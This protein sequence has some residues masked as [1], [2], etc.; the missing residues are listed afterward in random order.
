MPRPKNI[1]YY[2]FLLLPA[3]AIRLAGSVAVI[4]DDPRLYVVDKGIEADAPSPVL[5]RP[6]LHNDSP[7]EQVFSLKY[8][9]Y[10]VEDMEIR[11]PEIVHDLLLEG[12][13]AVHVEI[14]CSG[15]QVLLVG[16]LGRQ[17]VGDEVAPVIKEGRIRVDDP[18]V[19]DLVPAG[20]TDLRYIL[21]HLRCH[22]TL[23]QQGP[24]R[25]AP[26]KGVQAAVFLSPKVRLFRVKIGPVPVQ[27]IERFSAPCGNVQSDLLPASQGYR[28]T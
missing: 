13:H 20:G 3:A 19:A 9:R 26:A 4:Q 2:L 23:V 21:P 28:E 1:S 8:G 25:S 27:G 11:I 6:C 14:P 18:P 22:H 24:G 12:Q 17:R 16:T 15:D 5:H 10:P 7:A